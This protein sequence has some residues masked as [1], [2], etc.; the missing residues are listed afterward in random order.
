MSNSI[1][2]I[3][4]NIKA[5]T[6]PHGCAPGACPICSGMGGGGM[7]PGERAQKPGEMSYHEC[8]MIGAMMKARALQ[9]KAHEA[10]LKHHAEN[11]AAFEKNMEALCAKA[12][13]IAS[14]ASKSILMKPIAF[15][16]NNFVIPLLN[17]AKNIPQIIQNISQKFSQIKTDIQDKLNAI[18][19]EAKAFIDKKV[20]EL[21]SNIKS[22][23]ELLSKI[24]KRNNTK[25]DETKIDEDKKI[26]RLKTFINKIIR[27]KKDDTENNSGS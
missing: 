19:G 22:K 8:A 5:G 14:F 20:S 17:V 7:R 16:V 26:F 12:A 23:F 24:F 13:E 15:V 6:C 10:N 11:V 2:N 4:N 1:H 18:F 25:D 21:V 3:N 9:T 27:K